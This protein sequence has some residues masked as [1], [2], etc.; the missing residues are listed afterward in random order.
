MNLDE[1]IKKSRKIH[2][3]N[4]NYSKFE[5]VNSKVKSILICK[6][7]NIEL[8]TTPGNN[9]IGKGC[10]NCYDIKRG[11]EHSGNKLKEKYPNW[12]FDLTTYRNSDSKIKYTCNNNHIG[13]SIYRNMIR[14]NVCKECNNISIIEKRKERISRN[15]LDVIKY[16]D[17][18]NISC[19]CLKCGFEKTDSYRNLYKKNYK[20]KSCILL[21]DS[22]LLQDGVLTLLKIE[23]YGKNSKILLLKCANG[24]EYKQERSNL[25]SNKGCNECRKQ[26]VVLD[27]NYVFNKFKEIHGNFF[28]YKD[29]NINNYKSLRDVLEITCRKGHNFKQKA[30]NH[31]Q[32]KGCPIC[33]ESSGERLIAVYLENKNIE[34]IRQKKFKDC[35]NINYLPFDFYIP[36]INLLI[37][38]DGI[39]HFES[40]PIFG[41]DEGFTKRLINDSIKNEYCKLYNKNLIRISYKDDVNSILN[42]IFE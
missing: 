5:Y 16:I 9:L 21:N 33:R 4:F 29:D 37:E 2:G 27:K 19:R 41:G 42:S 6:K 17:E 1:F 7:C 23:N 3:D 12:L 28:K 18:Y 35:K 11:L 30:S 32:G 26:S 22:K 39:Q 24:H 34:F 10:K 31:L 20:C 15:S 13:E 38:Y 36:S 25:L 14:F 40:V 8:V